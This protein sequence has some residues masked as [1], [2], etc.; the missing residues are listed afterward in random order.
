[1]A[2]HDSTHRAAGFENVSDD[3]R[4]ALAH[5]TALLEW[6]IRNESGHAG[7]SFADECRIGTNQVLK[8]RAGSAKNHAQI[9]LC[10]FR[11]FQL[12]APR[13]SMA[14]KRDGPNCSRTCT[15]GTLSDFTSA[16]E[17]LTGP[18]NDC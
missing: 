2:F 10:A 11:K 6:R 9:R 8:S 12:Q 18:W 5:H 15:A 1:S 13:R 7:Q 14:T 3:E 17:T 4:C 16:S